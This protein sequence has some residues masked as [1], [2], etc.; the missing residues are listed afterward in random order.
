MIFL[1]FIAPQPEVYSRD[2]LLSLRSRAAVLDRQQCLL[3]TH[4]GLR[5]RGCRGGQHRRRPLQPANVVTS[6]VGVPAAFVSRNQLIDPGFST[7]H[8]TT[9]SPSVSQTPTSIPVLLQS[10][11]TSQSHQLLLPTDC[12]L[13]RSTLRV[14]SPNVL[15]S[16]SLS[17]L[18]L[19]S[20]FDGGA[21]VTDEPPALSLPVTTNTLLPADYHPLSSQQLSSSL[22]DE[23]DQLSDRDS[24]SWFDVRSPPSLEASFESAVSE[25]SEFDVPSSLCSSNLT[26]TDTDLDLQVFSI[27]TVIGFRPFQCKQRNKHSCSLTTVNTVPFLMPNILAANIRGGLCNKLDEL[28]AIFDNNFVDIGCISETWLKTS[29]DDSALVISNY[30]CY[31]NDRADGRQGGGVAVYVKSN[32]SCTHLHHYSVAGLETLWILC[33]YP[34]MPRSLSHILIGVIYHPPDGNKHSMISHILDC[35]DQTS[36][37]HPNLGIILV[38]D[39]NQLPDQSIRAYPLRQVVASAT[40]GKALLDK[41]FTNM[42]DWYSTPANLPAV[43]SSDHAAV[44][45]QTSNSP[46]Y[47]PGTDIVVS[48]RV[49]DHNRKVLLAHELANINWSALYQME[50]CEDMVTHFY[51]TVKTVYDAYLPVCNFKRHSSDK[52]WVTDRF[53][54]LI[55]CRQFAYQTGNM[56]AFRKYRNA[57]QRLG[58]KLRQQYYNKQVSRLRQSDPRKWWKNVKQFIGP[59]CNG[60][61][62]EVEGMARDLYDGDV[63]RM[64][65]DIN[66]FFV[67]IASDIPPLCGDI[68]MSFNTAE[69]D[70]DTDD[71]CEFDKFVMYPWEVELKLSKIC[72]YK[73][74]GPDELPNCC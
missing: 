36:H 6:S 60:D 27:P 55:R 28:S 46:N 34:R 38:G 42:Y 70:G 57:A 25:L 29:I 1:V 68:L 43:G 14:P 24:D 50:L 64:A 58:K 73:A 21:D 63:D 37:Q 30:V 71:H 53:R 19:Q 59:T 13:T 65:E 51:N 40:R 49:C 26:D 35:L 66:H 11:A 18:L 62:N 67:N 17:S 15:S 61:R 12:C 48:R 23:E 47:K 39:F 72:T 74:P 4:L 9:A 69:H 10:D 20:S 5:R 22:L 2:G 16:S 52:P 56:T 31:R 32:L 54:L 8:T 45:M 3:I 7:R 44:L 33:R 41:I